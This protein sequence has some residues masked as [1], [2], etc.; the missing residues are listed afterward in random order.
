MK[1]SRHVNA[2][3]RVRDISED[4]LATIMELIET[5]ARSATYETFETHE[6]IS[7]AMGVANRMPGT[8]LIPAKVKST[9][10]HKLLH[11]YASTPAPNSDP[12]PW[13]D[14]TGH[15]YPGHWSARMTRMRYQPR[16]RYTGSRK[17]AGNQLLISYRLDNAHLDS[18]PEKIKS[19][20]R[21]HNAIPKIDG[22]NAHARKVLRRYVALLKATS[23]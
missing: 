6:S 21:L 15:R 10:H 2:T 23:Y 14:Y 19:A 16:S 7:H 22:P 13:T 1:G 8:R 9:S 18:A 12:K 11:I 5:E 4:A 20:I 17:H 3:I